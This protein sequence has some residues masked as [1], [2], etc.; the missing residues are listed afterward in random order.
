MRLSEFWRLMDDEFGE[1]Y[2]RTL[3]A[4]QSLTAFGGRTV[5]ELVEAGEPPRRV[6]EALAEQMDVP[7]ERRLGRDR[8]IRERPGFE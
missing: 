7:V 1:S 5:A 8:P 3:A 4:Q 2:S 6:W